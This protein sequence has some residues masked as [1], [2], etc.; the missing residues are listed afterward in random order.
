M[1]PGY[2][3]KPNGCMPNAMWSSKMVCLPPSSWPNEFVLTLGARMKLIFLFPNR[4]LD[5]H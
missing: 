2:S 4:P 1:P 3:M 5:L